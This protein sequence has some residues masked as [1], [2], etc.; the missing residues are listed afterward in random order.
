MRDEEGRVVAK[1]EAQSQVQGVRIK[2]EFNHKPAGNPGYLFTLRMR[3]QQVNQVGKRSAHRV[4]RQ[5]S[6]P[7]KPRHSRSNNKT[8]QSAPS[9][10]Q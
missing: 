10:A 5:W 7:W 6:K 9:N 2:K 3:H 4:D 1:E 8:I